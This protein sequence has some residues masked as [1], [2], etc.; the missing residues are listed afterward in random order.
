M[1]TVDFTKHMQALLEMSKD[2]NRIKSENML[3]RQ[4]LEDAKKREKELIEKHQKEMFEI[5]CGNINPQELS[6][7]LIEKLITELDDW[8]SAMHGSDYCEI[9]N[10]NSCSSEYYDNAR[11][12]MGENFS[13]RSKIIQQI[14]T[15]LEKS[16]GIE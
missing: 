5:S 11:T 15:L 12:L 1:N 7:I 9:Q 3:F 14:Q 13:N 8:S 4:Q 10:S 2:F 16:D 6:E